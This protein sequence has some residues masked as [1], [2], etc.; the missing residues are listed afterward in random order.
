MWNIAQQL[1]NDDSGVII[2]AELV[3]VLTIAVLSVIVGL[4]EAVGAAITELTDFS[5][6]LGAMN[7]SYMFTGFQSL[8]DSCGPCKIKSKVYGSTWEDGRDMCDED[9]GSQ[10]MLVC[11]IVGEGADFCP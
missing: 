11:E 6:A 4:H 3:L 9:D 7:Q 1:W 5:A 10:D 8:S 2:S